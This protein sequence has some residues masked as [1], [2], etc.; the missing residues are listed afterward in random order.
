MNH[1]DDVP[2]CMVP[3][4]NRH[5]CCIQSRDPRRPDGCALNL[6][7]SLTE[8]MRSEWVREGTTD[9]SGW[10]VQRQEEDGTTEVR[11]RSPR[12]CPAQP[13]GRSSLGSGFRRRLFG[14]SDSFRPLSTAALLRTLFSLLFSSPNDGPYEAVR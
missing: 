2:S 11:E 6:L 1:V 4:T 5:R 3:P 9:V 14:C 7:Y 10:E 13:R 12:F 8:D